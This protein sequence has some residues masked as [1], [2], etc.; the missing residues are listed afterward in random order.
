MSFHRWLQNLRS[1]LATG[2]GQ[3]HHQRRSSHRAVTHRP[4]L[5]RLEDRSVPAFLAP[6][7]YTVGSSPTDVKTGDFN[8]DRIPDLATLDIGSGSVSVLLGNP[9]G[10]FQ[11]ARSSYAGDGAP[12]SSLAV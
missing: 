5:E 2:R 7:D 6:V 12:L 4:N 3:R 9:N 10:T 11:P 1:A 8:G